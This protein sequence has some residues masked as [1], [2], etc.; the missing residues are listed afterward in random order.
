MRV[1]NLCKDGTRGTPGRDFIH[2]PPSPRS[3]SPYT[4]G[5]KTHSARLLAG[6]AW[7][8][9]LA[10]LGGGRRNTDGG[11]GALLHGQLAH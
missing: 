9:G 7:H 8:E 3:K 4:P 6:V 1:V 5:M 10:M 2:A 11:W